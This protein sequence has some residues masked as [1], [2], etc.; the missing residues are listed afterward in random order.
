MTDD[1]LAPLR[2]R[3][4]ERCGNAAARLRAFLAGGDEPEL[5]DMIHRLAGSAGLF[6]YAE[7]G[8]MAEALDAGFAEGRRPTSQALS[9]LADA[10]ERLAAV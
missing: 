4:R 3:F 7:V 6:G 10:L 2:T 8:A 5:E 1:P 9:D